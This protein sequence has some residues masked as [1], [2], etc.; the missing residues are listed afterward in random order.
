MKNRISIKILLLLVFSFMANLCWC[1][2][3]VLSKHQMTKIFRPDD[4]HT[5]WTICNQDSSFFKADTLRLY[6]NIN[7]FYQKS[8]CCRLVQW[9]FY[10]KNAFR[11]PILQ[12]CTEPASGSVLTENDYFKIKF[13]SDKSG[14][15][16]FVLNR[17]YPPDFFKVIGLQEV[18]LANNNK[19]RVIL[20]KRLMSKRPIVAPLY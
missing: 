10:R 9:D 12:I 3:N 11:R 15:Y 2:N 7:Y 18:G 4:D 8:D 14:L 20:L 17:K 6:D 5:E 13:L 1:Q 19:S 16:L